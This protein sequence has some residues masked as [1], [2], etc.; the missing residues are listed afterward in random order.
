M[1]LPQG[2]EEYYLSLFQ[3]AEA[4]QDRQAR[5]NLRTQY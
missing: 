3:Q 4:N 5:Q 1:A 2:R